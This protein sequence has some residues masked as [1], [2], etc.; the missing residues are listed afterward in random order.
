MLYLCS[1]RIKMNIMIIDLPF[2]VIL[3]SFKSVIQTFNSAMN[4]PGM[5]YPP[6]V[7][8]GSNHFQMRND[9]NTGRAVRR[10]FVNGLD[11]PYFQTDFR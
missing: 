9:S 6:Q 5:N 1:V 8:I 11:R 7:M 3:K 2:C 4:A 10:I